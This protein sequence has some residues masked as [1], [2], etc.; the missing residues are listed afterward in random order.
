MWEATTLT[1]QLGD[2]EIRGEESERGETVREFE[3]VRKFQ[4]HAASVGIHGLR[5]HLLI[6]MKSQL[7]TS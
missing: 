3:K 4:E 6:R 2:R 5:L 7:G 1:G